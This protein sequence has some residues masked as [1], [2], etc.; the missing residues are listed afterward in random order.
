[1]PDKDVAFTGNWIIN[2][3]TI[4]FNS[5]GGSP[6]DPITLDYGTTVTAPADPTKTGYT[7]TSWDVEVPTSMPAENK[8]FTAQWT[9][10]TYAVSYAIT[11][12][13]PV[14]APAAPTVDMAVAYGMQKLVA[15]ALTFTGYTFSGW[16]TQDV[17]VTYGNY[18]MPDKDVSFTGS[19]TANTHV[20]SYTLTGTVPTGSPTAPTGE[21][22]VA[23]GTQKT[24]AEVLTFAGYTF[25]GWAT[26]DATVTNGNYST[27]SL[28]APNITIIEAISGKS[29]KITWNEISEATGYVLERRA[30]KTGPFSVVY[31][32]TDTTYTNIKLKA[33][34]VYYYRVK[35]TKVFNGTLYSSSLSPLV[36]YVP[37]AAPTISHPVLLSEN[38]VKITWGAA[39]HD[40][41]YQLCRSTT[42]TGI[43]TEVYAGKLRTYSDKGEISGTPYYYK[44]RAYITSETVTLYGLFSKIVK[45][46]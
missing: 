21:T 12:T 29:I 5:A 42:K 4:T 20:V 43:Y 31:T 7:F 16:T 37:L 26:T 22:A 14:G 8:M 33:G 38:E 40:V 30:S 10:N 24:V 35:A 23:Y 1:M 39:A 11:G 36:G 28:P 9:V 19:W 6:V 17:T 18:S 46:K 32:G 34:I 13:V 44:V 3:Y 25:S 27:P 15:A 2:Q 45:Q 41:K